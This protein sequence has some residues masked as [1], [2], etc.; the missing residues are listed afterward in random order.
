MKT[1]A[2]ITKNAIG[3]W[4]K[5]QLPSGVGDWSGFKATVFK[6]MHELLWQSMLSLQDAV[7]NKL[8]TNNIN[9]K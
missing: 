8:V 4:N 3:N 5:Y 9:K 2:Q 7:S 6:F 1:T